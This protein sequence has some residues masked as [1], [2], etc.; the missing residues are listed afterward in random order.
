MRL[1]AI[2]LVLASAAGAQ[3]RLRVAPG[4]SC[5]ESLRREL[6]RI[7]A[8][9]LVETDAEVSAS[10]NAKPPGWKLKVERAGAEALERSLDARDCAE[11]SFA[12]AVVVERY[13]H[14]LAKPKPVVVEAPKKHGHPPSSAPAEHLLPPAGEGTAPAPETAPIPAPPPLSTTTTASNETSPPPA[15]ETSPTT[16]V[17]PNTVVVSEN[18]TAPPKT[19]PASEQ[20]PAQT[21][22]QTAPSPPSAPFLRWQRWELSVSGAG[23]TPAPSGTRF[24]LG[25][26]GAIVFDPAWRASLELAG[27]LP[28][29][30]M[31]VIN[32]VQRGSMSVETFNAL[33]T[34]GRCIDRELRP[35]LALV[36]GA[37]VARG[38]TS[39]DLI[40]HQNA[41]FQVRP[42]FGLAL[43]L[44]WLP[45]SWIF[46]GLELVG[47]WNP[48]PAEFDLQGVPAATVTFPTFEAMLRLSFGATFT[49]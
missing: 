32:G 10:L 36:G 2:T 25:L 17:S 4:S 21:A 28:E 24:A 20:P 34:V 9:K 33:L 8:T 41:S 13:L 46:A 47:L 35:C 44:Q 15:A 45:W 49:R 26:E 18:E 1:L 7:A 48:V 27:G 16:T 37:R 23:W 39:G 22:A 3:T 19:T 42:S 29:D 40:F 38:T 30:Q 5:D 12:A 31:I 11:A 43:Q 14:E 6:S